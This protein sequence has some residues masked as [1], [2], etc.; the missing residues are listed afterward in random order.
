MRSVLG[1]DAAWTEKNPSGLALVVETEA[2]WSL[3][4]ISKSYGQFIGSDP[5][6]NTPDIA[7]LISSCVEK[8]GRRPDIVAVDMPLSHKPIEKRRTS[9][10]EISKEFV[11]FKAPTHSP[12]PTRPGRLADQIREDF[13]SVGYS[14]C[15]ATGLQIPGVIEVYPHAALIRLTGDKIRLEYKTGKTKKYWPHIEDLDERRRLLRQVWQ[16]IVETLNR[17]IDGVAEK[18]PIPSPEQVGAALK[19]FEDQ[20]DAVVCAYVAIAALEG[21]ARAFGDADSAIWVPAP[22]VA[23]PA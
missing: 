22:S 8:I 12:L 18:L 2:G 16:R 17:E 9:D 4:S 10:T 14:L 11:A 13:V 20:L 23:G 3:N 1:I 15:T 7:K 19:E 5:K 6:S 21:R